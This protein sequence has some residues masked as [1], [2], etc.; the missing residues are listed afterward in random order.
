MFHTGNERGATLLLLFQ[1]MSMCSIGSAKY[2]AYWGKADRYH[3]AF[4]RLVW[5]SLDVAAVA[6]EL[7]LQRGDW[8]RQW[9]LLTG[10]E[11]DD[12]RALAVWLIGLHDIGKF[13][14]SFQHLRPDLREK[15]FPDITVQ[16][17]SYDIRHDQLG[18]ILWSKKL[19]SELGRSLPT[20]T[21]RTV[22]Q[23]LDVWMLS[24]TGHHGSPPSVGP[25]SIGSYFHSV[26]IA[27][28]VSFM[29]EWTAVVNPPFDSL[30]KGKPQPEAGSWLLAGLAVLSD[31]LGSNS[32]IFKFVDSAQSLD[33]YWVDKALPQAAVAVQVAG[34]VGA[35]SSGLIKASGF[36]SMYPDYDA[37][38][39]Q[40]ACDKVAVHPEPQL[41]ILEDVTGAGKTEAAMVLAQRLNAAEQGLGMYVGLPTMA[42]A[43]AMYERMASS[44]RALFPDNADPSL[45]L[46]HSARHLSD[47]FRSSLLTASVVGNGYG[48]EKNVSAQCNRWL[49]DNR[50]KALLSDVGVGTIDQALLATMPARHQSLRLLGLT[51]KVLV[52]DE[53]H[54]YDCYTRELLHALL[55]F[56]AALGGSVVLLS[57]TLTARQKQGLIAAFRGNSS[58]KALQC[59]D[60]YPLLTHVSA[61]HLEQTHVATRRSVQRHVKVV[62]LND[63]DSVIEIIREAVSLGRCVCWVRN[64]VADVRDGRQLLSSSAVVDDERLHV[65]HSRFAMGERLDIEQRM[66]SLFGKSSTAQHRAA[67]VLVAS[68]VVEQSLDLDFDVMITDVAPID[69]MIQRAGRLQRH[70]RD[71][72]GD[73]SDEELRGGCCLYVYGPAPVDAPD[74]DWLK[75]VL[76]GA[77]AVYP[78]TVVL[79]RGLRWLQAQGGWRMPD[80]ARAMLEY[81]YDEGGEVPDGLIN[82][83]G[84]RIGDEMS[85]RDM[86]KFS[87]LK[88]ERGYRREAQW[89]DDAK[90]ETRLGDESRTIYLARWAG[91]QLT[92]WCN[93]GDF[94]WDMSN[95]RVRAEQLAAIVAP[96][97]SA[98]KALGSL[99][100]DSSNRF[101]EHDLI[102]P[103]L[104]DS[105]GQWRCAGLSA[106]NKPRVVAYIRHTGL[107]IL[108]E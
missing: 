19:R 52:L 12:A 99:V 61:G 77:N 2:F 26:D 81:V 69:L 24:V 22:I 15:F 95:V 89:D 105:S 10:L 59:S 14:E 5:H 88:F 100:A 38:P 41:Y 102:V 94:P 54:A 46:S 82:S 64:T 9:A 51:G 43:N 70:V 92:P 28:A 11:S 78:H 75:R 16:R 91:E 58:K 40:L 21:A 98:Q 3:T 71:E 44:Y 84:E 50:K 6:N 107:E 60:E 18:H 42:T 104:C 47:A 73:L 27:A 25:S 1:R 68:Q 83:E 65:F 48:N 34:I 31:W 57:A 62:L 93:D 30:A 36:A 79:W 45:I 85:R 67:R 23:L 74:S 37:T 29:H 53:V 106:K 63:I 90:I 108:F 80:D 87:A 7:L 39:L 66:L 96:S 4:H 103:L 49:A 101:D 76:P 33:S 97:S 13:A 8:C 32:D 20:E 35:S 56:H 55:R 72:A 86:G 17:K